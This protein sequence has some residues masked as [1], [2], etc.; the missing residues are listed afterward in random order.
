MSAL[1]DPRWTALPDDA[2]KRLLEEHRDLNVEHDWSDETI[3]EFK[4]KALVLGIKVDDVYWSGFWS[5][6]DG[7]CFTGRIVDWDEFLKAVKP[8][9]DPGI[10]GW[11]RDNST[12]M[13]IKTGGS[14]CHS[15]TMYV[16]FCYQDLDQPSDLE[17][18][19]LSLWKV[20][21][22][23]GNILYE[24][25][26]DILTYLRDL[27][28]DLYRELEKEYE[29]LTCDEAVVDALLANHEDLNSLVDDHELVS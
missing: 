13:Q 1:K 25:E 3:A 16:D 19:Q 24:M 28:D 14:Y 7:A 5:Q 12:R 22:K 20:L 9:I 21:T 6:G 26:R 17:D 4:A 11:V 27:A 15:G 2:Q 8:D 10:A 18:L 23:N 29:Y